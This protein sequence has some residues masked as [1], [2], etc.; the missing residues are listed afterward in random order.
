MI[1][2][3]SSKLDASMIPYEKLVQNLLSSFHKAHLTYQLWESAVCD[4]SHLFSFLSFRQNQ[5]VSLAVWGAVPGA[6]LRGCRCRCPRS[7][8]GAGVM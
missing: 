3:V 6:P 2:K 1:L 4:I 8:A 5:R 7:G